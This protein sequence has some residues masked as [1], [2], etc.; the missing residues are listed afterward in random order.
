[1]DLIEA[2]GYIYIRYHKSYDEFQAIKL[3]MTYDFIESDKKYRMNE[4]IKGK[5]LII[6]EIPYYL[7]EKIYN[8]LRYYFLKFNIKYDSSVDFYSSDIIFELDQF[9]IKFKYIYRKLNC[10]EIENIEKKLYESNI[11][12][13]YISN[14][15]S[16]IY[17][18][19]F[20]ESFED[21]CN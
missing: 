8:H 16:I 18:Y 14:I 19:N 1:M 21:K 2:F 5:Y 11:D 6:Y 13:N 3:G 9:F 15:D 7:L 12:D 17:R 10:S 20:I 4:I